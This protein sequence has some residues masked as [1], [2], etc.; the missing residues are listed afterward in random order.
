EAMRRAQA[1]ADASAA[2]VR[3]LLERAE[4]FDRRKDA[5]LA[6]LAHELRNPLAPLGNALQL[7]SMRN[8]DP[9]EAAEL[10]AIMSRQLSQ[11]VRLIDDLMDVSRIKHGRVQLRRAQ[12]QLR[13]LISGAVEAAQ[14]LVDY[15]RHRLAVDVPDE[16][17]WIDA[18]PARLTQVFTNMLINAAK[19]SGTDRD[20]SVSARRLADGVVVRVHDDGAGIPTDMLAKIFEPF[21]QVDVR[22]TRF[23]AG[24]GIGLALVKQLI[25]LHGGTVEAHSEGAERGSE[26]TVTLPIVPPP[27]VSVDGTPSAVQARAAALRQLGLPRHKIVVADDVVESAATLAKLLEAMGQEVSVAHDGLATIERINALHSD[28]AIVD[29]GMPGIDGYEVARRLRAEP[30]T[31]SMTLVALTGY[32]QE[33]D[34]AAAM[35]AGFNYHFT[36]PINLDQLQPLLVGQ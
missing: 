24:L 25:E 32:G 5:F 36:K 21:T 4:D 19:H 9:V 3:S 33:H 13:P 2:E 12:I 8:P 35:A 20:I 11:M 16:P 18:D 29:I 22:P 26:F 17:I 7:W 10:R 28:L 6:T 31:S 30:A 34:R 14:P 23:Y 15:F 27:S 1:R